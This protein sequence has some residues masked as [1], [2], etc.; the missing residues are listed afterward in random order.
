MLPIN[1]GLLVYAEVN[2]PAELFRDMG[3]NTES[4]K[5]RSL[6]DSAK[7]VFGITS[8]NFYISKES[9]VYKFVILSG[10]V[11]NRQIVGELYYIP[12]DRRLDI[13]T[14]GDTVPILQFKG[15]GVVF[16][17]YSEFYEK[18]GFVKLFERLT[19]NL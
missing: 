5:V 15:K 2:K 18:L 16:R 11:R 12:K 19:S 13:W 10:P 7:S 4:G 17:N 14:A 1:Y 8:V 9:G 6:F 3:N